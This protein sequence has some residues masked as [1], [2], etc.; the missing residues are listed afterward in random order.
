VPPETEVKVSK[1]FNFRSDNM[2]FLKETGSAFRG[3]KTGLRSSEFR[4][5]LLMLLLFLVL[6]HSPVHSSSSSA[7]QVFDNLNFSNEIFRQKRFPGVDL[8]IKL[9]FFVTEEAES[10]IREH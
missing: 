3:R 8:I 2:L 5:L 9:F 4:H 10:Q 1:C 6:S 7:T